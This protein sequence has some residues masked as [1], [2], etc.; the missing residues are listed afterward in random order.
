MGTYRVV[1]SQ[2]TPSPACNSPLSKSDVPAFTLCLSSSELVPR[3]PTHS[4]VPRRRPA[5]RT[6]IST[7]KKVSTR[8]SS[9]RNQFIAAPHN[10]LL[11]HVGSSVSTE[12]Q[13]PH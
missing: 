11:S 5:T 3:H 7:F 2:C 6:A 9:L 8:R 13:S 12:T 4:H 1:I 10:P